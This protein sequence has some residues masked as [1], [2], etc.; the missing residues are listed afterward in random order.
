MKRNL[1]STPV[2]SAGLKSPPAISPCPPTSR[3]GSMESA[4]RPGEGV[5]RIR[6]RDAVRHSPT[7]AYNS[8]RYGPSSRSEHTRSV[9]LRCLP[10]AGA[11]DVA[12]S[13]IGSLGP[14]LLAVAESGAGPA[15]LS[16]SPPR[17]C[18]RRAPWTSS[19]RTR[20]LALPPPVH[21]V[22]S[23]V[24]TSAGALRPSSTTTGSRESAPGSGAASSS[25]KPSGME[26]HS[27]ADVGTVCWPPGPAG[28]SLERTGK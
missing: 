6:V 26:R 27:P 5:T 2:P 1:P 8:G 25:G 15:G 12:A 11:Q 13:L 16:S 14:R 9:S 18:G 3:Q 17:D 10:G 20:H 19:E 23:R 24:A 21:A 7:C 22:A 28:T 4:M